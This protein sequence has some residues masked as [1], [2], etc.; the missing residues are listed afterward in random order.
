MTESAAMSAV[1]IRTKT[2]IVVLTAAV[3][4]V[5]ALLHAPGMNGPA[6]WKWAWRRV[7]FL[8]VYTLLP[9]SA[10]PVFLA[11]FLRRSR[12]RERAIAVALLTLGTLTFRYASVFVQTRPPSFELISTI[13]RSEAATSYYT[14]ALGLSR[15]DGWFGASDQ[16][17]R[18]PGLHLH[19]ISKPPG[20]VLFFSAMIRTFGD[21]D[22]G[23][24]VAAAIMG[25]LAVL[26]VPATYL[27]LTRLTT[28]HEAAFCGAS[29][30][31]LSPGFALFFPMFDPIYIL[32]SCALI[33]SWSKAV[34]DDSN[35]A[36]IAM[37]VVLAVV[38]LV[39]FSVLVVG[40]FCALYPLVVRRTSVAKLCRRAAL[41]FATAALTLAA[42][43][44]VSGYN[45]VATFQS[46]W[47]N[48]HALLARYADQRPYPRT[49]L[50][51]LT[52][53]GLGTGWISVPL[54]IFCCLGAK[55]HRAIALLAVAQLVLVAV[56]GLLQAET[57]RV[58]NFMMP[59]LMIPV[60]M[61]LSGWPIRA[62]WTVLLGVLAVTCAVCQ[63]MK[64][65]F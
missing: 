4:V 62:R 56:L 5:L 26:G 29:F 54:A 45:A 13:I 57:A 10:A 55:Q 59:L 12:P 20:P 39:T 30:L 8:P 61:E 21:T 51:D 33:G 31:S 3:V 50:F 53:F 32:L 49:I 46:A 42:L 15:V 47:A 22:L 65:I 18:L 25:L 48:Q 34:D 1:S 44:L 36:A 2:W 40:F 6:Y 35:L 64:F 19:T 7:D 27:L 38:C 58:W 17:L 52:D 24:H 37:G 43:W 23:I 63:N 9:L 16:V 60:G 11:Q 41:V 28:S 14:D